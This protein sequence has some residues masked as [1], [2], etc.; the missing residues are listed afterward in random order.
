MCN[1]GSP[2]YSEEPSSCLC[3]RVTQDLAPEVDNITSF[4]CIHELQT[5][6]QETQI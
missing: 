1:H 4:L 5:V 2:L 3:H 6:L